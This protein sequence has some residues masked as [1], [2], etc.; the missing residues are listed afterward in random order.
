[1]NKAAS[2]RPVRC[3]A[4]VSNL[5]SNPPSN[6]RHFTLTQPCP[7]AFDSDFVLHNVLRAFRAP[8]YSQLLAQTPTRLQCD[9]RWASHTCFEALRSFLLRPR[10]R[11]ARSNRRQIPS[12]LSFVIKEP[13]RPINTLSI[14]ARHRLRDPSHALIV[15]RRTTDGI[16]GPMVRDPVYGERAADVDGVL[17]VRPIAAFI[18]FADD[19]VAEVFELV[20]RWEADSLAIDAGA[21]VA[22]ACVVPGC[23]GLVGGEEEAEG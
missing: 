15:V 10:R 14:P 1:M 18:A 12:P 4:P 23:K 11:E 3:H 13:H 21:G 6:P 19:V 20:V 16:R 5:I 22:A 8:R 17:D 2:T 7:F 9:D